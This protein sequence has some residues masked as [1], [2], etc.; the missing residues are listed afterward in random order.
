M[1]LLA[2]ALGLLA[3]GLLSEVEHPP[4]WHIGIIAEVV[5][6]PVCVGLGIATRGIFTEWKGV[7]ATGTMLA[8]GL[9][10]YLLL[11]FFSATNPPLNTGYAR[12]VEGFVHTLTRGQIESV[13]PTDSFG[14][15]AEQLWV[16]GDSARASFGVI[17]ALPVLILF[18]FFRRL[19]AG[20]R[21]WMLGL[22]A[23]FLCLTLLM[24]ALLN[25]SPDRSDLVLVERFY[26][27]SHLILA[28]WV[29]YGL[30][31]L[32]TIMTRAKCTQDTISRFFANSIA[33]TRRSGL[34]DATLYGQRIQPY[35]TCCPARGY[36]VSPDHLQIA[37]P[38]LGPNT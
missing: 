3:D 37:T 33:V 34:L 26:G 38:G 14:R 6:L 23:V 12:T 31:L 11:P 28:I 20:E 5:L 29:G 35:P 32:G 25:P 15:Y 19:G 16:N 30:A 21:R 22:L 24:I 17:Y 8:L 2:H 7:L 1:A 13:R 9:S 27:A 18:W 10:V 36:Q 4:M